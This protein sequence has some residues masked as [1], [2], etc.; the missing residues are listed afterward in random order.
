MGLQ[1]NG[2]YTRM[3]KV[4]YIAHCLQC[5][6]NIALYEGVIKV[7]E[8]TKKTGVI[9]VATATQAM[10]KLHRRPSSYIQCIE[11]KPG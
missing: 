11:E 5:M 7:T 4:A 6:H 8:R 10:L 2:C 3:L 9:I 1:F